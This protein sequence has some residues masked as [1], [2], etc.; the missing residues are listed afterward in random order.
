MLQKSPLYLRRRIINAVTP[1]Q[2]PP[3]SKNK[4]PYPA[5]GKVAKI[6]LIKSQKR[7]VA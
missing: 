1:A 5:A 7:L 3:K 2:M 4:A 6:A